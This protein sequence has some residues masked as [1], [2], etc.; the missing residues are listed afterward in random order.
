MI[1]VDYSTM[2]TICENPVVSDIVLTRG[3]KEP[4]NSQQSSPAVRSFSQ[5]ESVPVEVDPLFKGT[6]KSMTGFPEPI[7]LKEMEL[8]PST[9]DEFEKRADE[10]VEK[11]LN[12]TK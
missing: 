10:L 1:G 9:L 2:Q 12:R 7:E 3:W 5:S 11:Y 6:F 4:E 8:K